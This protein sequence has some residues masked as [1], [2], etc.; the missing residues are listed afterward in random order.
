MERMKRKALLGIVILIAL[1]SVTS[2]SQ[3]MCET[4]NITLTAGCS[5]T[6]SFIVENPN[7]KNLHL[8]IKYEILPDQEGIEVKILKNIVVKKNSFEEIPFTVNTSMLLAP[9]TYIIE[10]TLYEVGNNGNHFGVYKK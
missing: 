9:Q 4:I 10:I 6:E 2:S 8:K 7:N 1:T 5:A 3:G